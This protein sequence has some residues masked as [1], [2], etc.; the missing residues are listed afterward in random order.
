M[1]SRYYLLYKRRENSFTFKNKGDILKQRIHIICDGAERGKSEEKY[2][3][4]DK[5]CIGIPSDHDRRRVDCGGI[6]RRCGS[7]VSN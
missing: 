1:N 3:R 5:A 6:C 2:I 4:Y 7:P